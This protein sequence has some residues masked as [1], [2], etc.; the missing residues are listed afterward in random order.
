MKKSI[1]LLELK[2]EE[3]LELSQEEYL[4]L[5]LARRDH[6]RIKQTLKKGLKLL[7]TIIILA[8]V[9]GIIVGGVS[10]YNENQRKNRIHQEELATCNLAREKVANGILLTFHE[11]ENISSFNDICSIEELGYEVHDFSEEELLRMK[12]NLKVYYDDYNDHN[13]SK[14][15]GNGEGYYPYYMRISDTSGTKILPK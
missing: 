2:E 10:L 14:Y 8:I 13:Y 12:L 5:K 11:L 7:L 4:E 3:G 15:F 6:K 1:R 9:C